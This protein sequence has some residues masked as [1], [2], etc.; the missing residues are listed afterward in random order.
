MKRFLFW[1][2]LIFFVTVIGYWMGSSA[3]SVEDKDL[4]LVGYDHAILHLKLL[5][6]IFDTDEFLK[7]LRKYRAMKTVKA[8]FVEVDSPGGAVGPSQELYY[9]FKL[10][11]EKYQ[12]PVVVYS[13]SLLASGAYYA[14]VGA[15]KVFVQPS[16]LVGSIG[17]IMRLVN[18]QELY[19]WAKIKHTVIK[20]GEF[21]DSGSETRELSPKEKAYFQDLANSSLDQFV[22]SIA[23]GRGLKI[24][25][26]RPYADGRVFSGLAATESKLVDG[27]KLFE[28]AVEATADLVKLEK[29]TYKLW[30]PPVEKS[31]L[32]MLGAPEALVSKG[33]LDQMA[34]R[35]ESFGRPM[36]LMPGSL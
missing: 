32:E 30:E 27:I 14:A 20:T 31:F 24:E 11:R 25:E 8:V 22:G 35:L 28:E 13:K 3:L 15:D 26:V 23:E 4:R 21:K 34:A 36:F 6:P 1:P 33:G 2:L 17:V 10:T 12:K 16:T 7:D 19:A 9:E 18:L 5:G 29:D